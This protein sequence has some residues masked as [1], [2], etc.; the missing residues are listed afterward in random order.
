MNLWID[1]EKESPEDWKWV[2]T[3]KKLLTSL[4]KE[5]IEKISIGEKLSILNIEDI[6]EILISNNIVV[7]E[8]IFHGTGNYTSLVSRLKKSGCNAKVKTRSYGKLHI[9][10]VQKTS[11][12]S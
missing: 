9:S 1:S 4:V 3:P 6:V 10:L 7:S 12:R 8:I 11:S 2:K 5:K